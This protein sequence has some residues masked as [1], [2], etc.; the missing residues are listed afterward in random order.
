MKGPASWICSV[1]R[2]LPMSDVDYASETEGAFCL[3]LVYMWQ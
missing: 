2:S 3:V 1:G